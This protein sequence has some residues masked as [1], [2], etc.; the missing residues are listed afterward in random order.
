DEEARG[1]CDR[2]AK[3]EKVK[4][5]VA[6]RQCD[7]AHLDY[8]DGSFDAVVSCYAYHRQKGEDPR[9]L[10]KESL[11]VLKKGGAFAL[12]DQFGLSNI[13]GDMDAFVEEL[14]AEGITKITYVPNV[15]DGKD[16][17]TRVMKTK[18]LV[19]GLGM[20]YGTK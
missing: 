11:R 8:E 20:I 7:L 16:Y 17:V 5:R 2:N 10:V 4:K 3:I 14:R 12:E 19:K 13:Y 6:F 1:Q 15:E 18:N 9:A